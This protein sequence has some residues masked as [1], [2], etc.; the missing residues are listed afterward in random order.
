MSHSH[1][2]TTSIDILPA[3]VACF[4]KRLGEQNRHLLT[5]IPSHNNKVNNEPH[6]RKYSLVSSF[7]IILLPCEARR[8]GSIILVTFSE[9]KQT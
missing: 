3:T 7:F 5:L 4:Q 6:P 9:S 2:I 8:K 1:Q